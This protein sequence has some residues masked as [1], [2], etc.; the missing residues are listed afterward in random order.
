MT[1]GVIRPGFQNLNGYE[2]IRT[3]RE[4]SVEEEDSLN[5]EIEADTG[6]SAGEAIAGLEI[7][8]ER[9]PSVIISDF[10]RMRHLTAR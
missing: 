9:L 1:W 10:K 4:A 2:L 8:M 3:F 5:M 6:P 7:A